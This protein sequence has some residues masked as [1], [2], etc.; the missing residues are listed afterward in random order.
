KIKKVDVAS[1]LYHFLAVSLLHS[2]WEKRPELRQLRQHF[3]LVKKPLWRFHFQK[4]LDALRDFLHLFH[5]KSQRHPPHA[6]KRIDQ[7][8]ESGSLRLFEQQ[9]GVVSR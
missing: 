8:R 4:S 3:D 2:L 7:H 6:S 9:R 1:F 5:L